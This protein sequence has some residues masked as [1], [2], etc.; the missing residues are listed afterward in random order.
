[1]IAV[2]ARQQLQSLRRQRVFVVTVGIL[3]SMTALAGLI[4][5]SSHTTILRVYDEATRYLAAQGRAAPPNPIDLKPSLALLANMEIYIPLIGALLALIVGHL[6]MA[7]DATTGI[8][9]LLFSRPLPRPAYVAGKALAVAI[10]LAGTL[11][12]C[13]V[14]S[15]VE[16]GLVNHAAPSL[17]ELGRIGLFYALSWLYLL[18]FAV[19]GMVAVLLT[20]RRPLA[21]LGALGVWL[22]VTFAMPEFTSGLHP[23]ASLNPVVDPVSTSQRLFQITAHARGASLFEQYKA[24]SAQLLAIDPVREPWG[25]IALRAL[26]IAALAAVAGAAGAWLVGRHDYSKGAS[27]A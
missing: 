25:Q 27:D 1:M 17:G 15:A 16:V 21:L 9:R 20:D 7:D 13:A 5:W 12:A 4:G 8:G 18:A 19:V 3:L 6:A 23:V 22:V 24:A 2:V 10:A 14:V 26:P 11:L